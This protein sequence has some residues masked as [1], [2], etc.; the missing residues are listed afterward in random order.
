MKKKREAERSIAPVIQ[1][2]DV[3]HAKSEEVL[4]FCIKELTEGSTW[5]ELRMK[6]GL[7]HAGVDGRWRVIK[8]ILCSAVMPANE[9]EA[10]KAA[11]S[12]SNYMQTQLE[13][14]SHYIDERCRAVHGSKN[15]DKF[16]KLKLETMKMQADEYSRRFEHY[17][18]L[19]AM[20]KA[21]RKQQGPSI[22]FQ[23]NY[24]VPRPGQ[25]VEW[26]D[27]RPV[28]DVPLPEPDAKRL[29]EVAIGSDEAD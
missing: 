8:E 5:N 7:G 26:K 21:D 24:F 15:E 25:K 4:Q 11:L 6:L 20:K 14:F 12:M 19:H 13:E 10:V 23:N 2:R 16:L 3:A 22:I 17:A 29:T 27:G 9:E 1:V 18:K 28:I